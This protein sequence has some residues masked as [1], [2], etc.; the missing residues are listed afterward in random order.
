MPDALVVAFADI[1]CAGSCNVCVNA[2]MRSLE[3][4]L[5]NSPW[6]ASRLH[7]SERNISPLPSDFCV[8]EA[9]AAVA[10]PPT[11]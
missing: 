10:E 5:M 8:I 7:N 4:S 9:V 2:S 11:S 6:S 3:H 1:N